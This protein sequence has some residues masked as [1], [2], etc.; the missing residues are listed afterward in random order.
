[1]ASRAAESPEKAP[2]QGAPASGKTRLGL[3]IGGVVAVVVVALAL[4]LGLG[5]GLKNRNN[6]GNTSSSG[7]S[8][9]GAPAA[10]PL[11]GTSGNGTG[12]LEDWRLD[13]SQYVL[14]LSWDLNAAPTTRHY[15]FAITEG[16]GWPDGASDPC[17]RIQNS[18]DDMLTEIQALCGT[19]SSSTEN[20]RAL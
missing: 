1:M 10:S 20:S 8:S 5:L 3:I 15:D 7:S 16:Q 12:K 6:S 17:R 11:P 4:G 14:D 2:K 13:T 18:S 9:G 19:W